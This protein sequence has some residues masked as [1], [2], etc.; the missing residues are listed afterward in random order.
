MAD[1]IRDILHTIT[2]GVEWTE[3]R[4]KA[5]IAL[6]TLASAYAAWK[7]ERWGWVIP[8]LTAW[9]GLSKPPGR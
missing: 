2:K 8:V 1:L 5:W 4:R 9:A 7:P 3:A 6:V